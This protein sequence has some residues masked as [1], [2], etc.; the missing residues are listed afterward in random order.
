M[1]LSQTTVRQILTRTCGFLRTV[2]SHSLQPYCGCALGN[3]LCGA[4][5]YVRHNFYITRGRQWGS[6]VE[7][8]T[9]AA[10]VYR[11]QY[12]RER[13]W[14]RRSRG[15][16]VI[17][18][19]SSTEPFQPA[20]RKYRVTRGV[21][22][23][24]V[25]RPPDGLIV[26]THC[27]QVA[28]YLHLYPELARRTEL[29]FHVSIESDL[30]RLPGLAPSASTVEKRLEACARLRGAG[31][32]TVVTV[33]PLLPMRDPERFFAR[34]ADVADAVAIDHF[35]GG[36]GSP[37]GTRTLRTR[38]PAAMAQV[39]PSSVALEYRE[40]IVEIARRRLPGR[41]GVNVEGFAGKYE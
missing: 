6:F 31:L 18:M 14:A 29:R 41:V 24:M 21:L 17:F 36:D 19:S 13:D 28:D 37:G 40:K 32:W 10:D 4:G 1:E 8:R 38:L 33:S 39:D 30:D 34:V 35:I 25:E 23:A 2:S 11:E 9:N 3:S 20:E 12:S 7:A 15:K 5:C 26:Q 27:P 22:E 16:F